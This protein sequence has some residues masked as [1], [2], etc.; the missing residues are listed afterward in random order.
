MDSTLQPPSKES[1]ECEHCGRVFKY[2]SK[3]SRHLLVH[4]KAKQF[5]C[6]YCDVAFSLSHNLR[7]HMRIHLGIKPFKCSYPGCEK[8]FTQSCN[9]KV[10]MK[11]HKILPSRTIFKSVDSEKVIM[12]AEVEINDEEVRDFDLETDNSDNPFC[13]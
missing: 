9:M 13:F 5:K 2:F 12:K 8:S 4:T 10:H 11:T 7:V 6:N 3:L 1:L